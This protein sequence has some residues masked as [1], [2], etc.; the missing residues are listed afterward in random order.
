[1]LPESLQR[2]HGPADARTLDSWPPGP[3][4]ESCCCSEPPACGAGSAALGG[5]WLLCRGAGSE[6]AAWPPAQPQP[7]RPAGEAGRPP[8]EAEVCTVHSCTRT[9]PHPASNF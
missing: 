4:E 6:A 2:E 1:M 5:D 7:R 8:S 3:G 9:R